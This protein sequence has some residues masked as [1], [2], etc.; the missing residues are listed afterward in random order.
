MA[1]QTGR[2]SCPFCNSFGVDRMYLGSSA[3]DSC[4]CTNCGARW[5]EEISDGAFRGRRHQERPTSTAAGNGRG[6]G[7]A[8]GRGPEAS[9]AGGEG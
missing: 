9:G 4:E 8:G 2:L 3:A 7:R 6:R 5:E 1:N